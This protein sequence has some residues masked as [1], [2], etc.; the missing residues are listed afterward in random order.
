MSRHRPVRLWCSHPGHLEENH[1]V[2]VQ[3]Q[4]INLKMVVNI[5]VGIIFISA[6]R[7]LVYLRSDG[8]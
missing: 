6:T 5:T 7:T 1:T 3:Y 2:G 4:G 8:A